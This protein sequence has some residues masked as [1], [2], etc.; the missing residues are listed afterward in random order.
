LDDSSFSSAASSAQGCVANNEDEERAGHENQ[1][2]DR[3]TRSEPHRSE[4]RLARRPLGGGR[5]GLRRMLFELGERSTGS[6]E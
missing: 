1:G 5:G 4:S 6:D 3:R 2:H